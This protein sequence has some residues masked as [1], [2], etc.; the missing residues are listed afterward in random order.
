MEVRPI[1]RFMLEMLRQTSMLKLN[2]QITQ[3]KV[4]FFNSDLLG[5][6]FEIEGRSDR[7]GPKL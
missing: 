7:V 3:I 2:G 5:I 6:Y 4:C 1:K